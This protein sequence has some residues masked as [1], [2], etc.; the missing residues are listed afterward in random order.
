MSLGRACDA[1]RQIRTSGRRGSGASRTPGVPRTRPRRKYPSSPS[2]RNIPAPSGTPEPSRSGPAIDRR[3]RSLHPGTRRSDSVRGLAA[4]SR[5]DSCRW[6]LRPGSGREYRVPR[7]GVVGLEPALDLLSSARPAV[8]PGTGKTL[9]T[10]V[11]TSTPLRRAPIVL[12]AHTW[13]SLAKTSCSR[14]QKPRLGSSASQVRSA[15]RP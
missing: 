8:Y 14:S 11:W 13:L 9:T 2:S 1:L 15:S 10:R 6:A 4:G 5:R 7:L 3:R 12:I